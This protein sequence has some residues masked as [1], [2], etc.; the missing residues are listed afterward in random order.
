MDAGRFDAA[1]RSLAGA[2]PRRT[3]LAAGVAVGVF[4][5]GELA[6]DD[7]LGKKKKKKKCK[8][9][10]RKCG[11]TCIEADACCVDTD[12]RE[13]AQCVSG[14]C[15][16]GTGLK[17]CDDACIPN[18]ACCKSSDCPANATCISGACDCNESLTLCGNAC[19]NLLTDPGNCRACG[20]ICPTGVCLGGFCTCASFAQDCS[21]SCSSCFARKEGSPAVCAEGASGQNCNSDADCTQAG[22]CLVN[23]K[24][25]RPCA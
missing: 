4:A 19:V 11:K 14:E 22:V 24:C 10:K 17:L 23:G 6:V 20:Q 18:S 9:G 12:C 25:A 7:V 8:G 5:A 3:L 1:V 2:V 21:T 13:L 16:C 15:V